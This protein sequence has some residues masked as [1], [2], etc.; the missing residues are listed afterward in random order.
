MPQD[1]EAGGRMNRNG[2]LRHTWLAAE[3]YLIIDSNEPF[4]TFLLSLDFVALF[5]T[6]RLNCGYLFG[7]DIWQPS[8]ATQ[9]W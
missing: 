8:A 5:R 3:P 2:V 6:D 4:S 9:K 1:R 7:L